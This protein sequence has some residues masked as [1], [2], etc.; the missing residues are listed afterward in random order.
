VIGLVEEHRGDE[1]ADGLVGVV[2]GTE[3]RGAIE[4][5]VG[6]GREPLI[7]LALEREIAIRVTAREQAGFDAVM[8]AVT[9]VRVRE[10]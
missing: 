4:R 1:R 8:A 5:V 7:D 6:Q 3:R 10:R 2:A 9:G